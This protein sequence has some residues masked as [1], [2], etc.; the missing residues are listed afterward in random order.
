MDSNNMFY[1]LPLWLQIYYY[2]ETNI[3]L[4][5]LLRMSTKKINKRLFNY[6]F[7]CCY[8]SFRISWYQITRN[9]DLITDDSEEGNKKY[10]YYRKIFYSSKNFLI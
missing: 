8:N 2:N 3:Y 5:S 10:N 1:E 6:D 9:Y 4:R 7:K